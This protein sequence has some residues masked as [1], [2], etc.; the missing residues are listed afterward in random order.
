MDDVKYDYYYDHLISNGDYYPPYAVSV[1]ERKNYRKK[2]QRFYTLS[3]HPG[4]SFLLLFHKFY[5]TSSR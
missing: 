4:K 3:E 2:A 1:P 5:F